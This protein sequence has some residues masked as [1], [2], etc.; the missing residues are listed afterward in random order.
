MNDADFKK[1]ELINVKCD[2][3][4]DDEEYENVFE[5]INLRGKNA[6]EE[7]EKKLKDKPLSVQ[8]NDYLLKI[9]D[10]KRG[11]AGVEKWGKF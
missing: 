11:A 4:I 6:R 2:V 3:L 7:L 9:S 8:C 10:P 5:I 1:L